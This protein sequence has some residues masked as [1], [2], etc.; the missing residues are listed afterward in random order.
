[1]SEGMSKEEAEAKADSFSVCVYSTNQEDGKPSED[2]YLD[3]LRKDFIKYQHIDN[4]G[5]K[6]SNVKD[7][8]DNLSE[9]EVKKAFKKQQL[10]Q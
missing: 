7:V 4:R 2:K 5:G 10:R 9:T 1:M 8:S 3:Q 6:W